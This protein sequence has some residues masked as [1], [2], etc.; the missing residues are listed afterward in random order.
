[1]ILWWKIEKM[2]KILTFAS[3]AFAVPTENFLKEKFDSLDSRLKRI[4]FK[5][6]YLKYM[7]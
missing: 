2:W 1:M 5:E 3:L 4:K 6:V 7:F